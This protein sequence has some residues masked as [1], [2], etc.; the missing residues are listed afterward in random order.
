MRRSRTARRWS[1]TS[2][3]TSIAA[4]ATLW[5]CRSTAPGCICSTPMGGRI[6]VDN[7]TVRA[8]AAG[9]GRPAWTNALF[10]L[11]Y[12]LALLVFIAVPLVLGA[13]LSLQ[14]YDMLGGFN[15]FV[16]IENFTNLLDDKI[17]LGTVRNTVL[18]VLMTAP[19]FVVLG[20]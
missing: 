20:L 11:P 8:V 19:A 3:A 2:P 12:L 9:I 15:G 14:D 6:M 7:A 10:V 13:W 16:G 5:N 18:F 1:M 17:F 4:S